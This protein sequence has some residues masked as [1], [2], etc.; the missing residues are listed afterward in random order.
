MQKLI[1]IALAAFL[2]SKWSLSGVKRTSKTIRR[3]TGRLGY[4]NRLANK[5]D[6]LCKLTIERLIASGYRAYRGSASKLL[7]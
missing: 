1:A 6:F 3:S 7:R 5:S 2:R 4:S